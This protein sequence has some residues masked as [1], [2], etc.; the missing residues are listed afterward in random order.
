MTVLT[1]D[2]SFPGARYM[3][4]LWVFFLC[5]HVCIFDF[6]L[7]ITALKMGCTP[8]A[9]QHLPSPPQLSKSQVFLSVCCRGCFVCLFLYYLCSANIHIV[10]EETGET[11]LSN[12]MKWWRSSGFDHMLKALNS[13]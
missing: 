11:C 5:V 13:I 3:L 1:R 9:R 7:H 12:Q 6:K 10:R 8:V 4:L 2:V